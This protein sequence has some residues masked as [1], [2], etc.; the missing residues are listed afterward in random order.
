MLNLKWEYKPNV[1][2]QYVFHSKEETITHQIEFERR[3]FDKSWKRKRKIMKLIGFGKVCYSYNLFKNDTYERL[4]W[5]DKSIDIKE[6]REIF[7][8][9]VVDKILS[10]K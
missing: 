2:N 5:H 8:D 7:G 3:L 10:L 1:R 6:A 4:E 9:L